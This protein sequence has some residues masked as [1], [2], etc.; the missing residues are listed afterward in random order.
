MLWSARERASGPVSLLPVALVTDEIVTDAHQRIQARVD[1]D[2]VLR[3]S[4][5]VLLQP[6]TLVREGK[7]RPGLGERLRDSP[8][9]TSLIRHA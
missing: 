6:L 5:H 8:G 2:P 1:T 4:R 3:E 9:Q 7:A